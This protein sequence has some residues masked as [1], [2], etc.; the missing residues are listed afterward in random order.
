MKRHE[1]EVQLT[2]EKLAEAE[3]KLVAELGENVC[4]YE[5]V[6]DKYAYKARQQNGHNQAIDW[7]EMLR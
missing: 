6:C 4:V 7:G 5:N 1:A 3:K 2:A